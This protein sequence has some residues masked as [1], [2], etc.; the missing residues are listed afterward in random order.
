MW[1]SGYGAGN[2]IGSASSCLGRYRQTGIEEY[3]ELFMTTAEAYYKAD[4]PQA[5]ILYPKNYSG[6][7]GMMMNAYKLTGEKHFLDKAIVYAD[8]SIEAIMDDSSPLPKASNKSHH[9]EAITGATGF[10][11]SLLGIWSLLNE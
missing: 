7:M 6:I 8:L 2:S 5:K 1:S 4:P 10:M 3:K 9:Y 11:N